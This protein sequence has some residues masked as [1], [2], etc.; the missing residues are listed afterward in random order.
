[1]V[2]H[3]S[4]CSQFWAYDWSEVENSNA[5]AISCSGNYLYHIQQIEDHSV[6]VASQKN[7][8]SLVII[9]GVNAAAVTACST[10]N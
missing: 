9:I 2:S 1:M 10:N 5:T 3:H 6:A 8:A 4:E 7:S